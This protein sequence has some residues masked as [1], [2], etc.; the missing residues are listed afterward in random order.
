MTSSLLAKVAIAAAA[1]IVTLT[2]ALADRGDHRRGNDYRVERHGHAHNHHHHYH[3]PRHFHFKK[4]WGKN[5]WH[6]QH[7][8]RGYGYNP[9]RRWN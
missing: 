8:G 1:T 9:Y 4:H 2:P 5:R 7:Y 3:G 6:R